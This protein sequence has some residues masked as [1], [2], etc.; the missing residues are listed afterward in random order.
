MAA[1]TLMSPPPQQPL[2]ELGSANLMDMDL[3]MAATTPQEK[4]SKKRKSELNGEASKKKKR[5]T[6]P[7]TPGSKHCHQCHQ[8]RDVFLECTYLTTR[9]KKTDR[10][11]KVFWYVP[12]KYRNEDT[13]LAPPPSP[14][15]P[16]MPFILFSSNLG[17]IKQWPVLICNASLSRI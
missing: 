11:G 12:S 5:E 3:E 4:P 13:Q 1:T 2:T 9:G 7:G 8:T 6:V 14:P 16:S 15:R 17:I 10:C